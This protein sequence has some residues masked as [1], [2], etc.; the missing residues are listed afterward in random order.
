MVDEGSVV[1]VGDW[2]LVIDGD[3]GLIELLVFFEYVY[4]FFV[5]VCLGF[6]VNGGVSGYLGFY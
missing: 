1:M 5:Y 2:D 3:V 4:D 6:D